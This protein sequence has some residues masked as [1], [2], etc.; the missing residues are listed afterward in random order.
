MPKRF[1][2][3]CRQLFDM[4][5]TGALRCPACQAAATARRNARAPGPA[6][7]YGPRHRAIRQQLI[8]QWT[9]GDPCA[10]CGHP[11]LDSAR[12]DLAHNEDRSGYKGLAHAACN[13]AT[14]RRR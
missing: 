3:D 8:A 5:S 9:Q 10:L 4:D 2:S 11:M 12:L 14:N 7:G 1:C 6:R 13:R